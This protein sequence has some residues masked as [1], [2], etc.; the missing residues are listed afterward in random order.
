MGLFTAVTDQD[1]GGPE[2]LQVVQVLKKG[3]KKKDVNKN[4]T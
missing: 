3:K 1:R 4:R 2:G